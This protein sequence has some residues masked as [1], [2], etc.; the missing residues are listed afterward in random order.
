MSSRLNKNGNIVSK[1]AHHTIVHLSCILE[2]VLSAATKAI[3]MSSIFPPAHTRT[4]LRRDRAGLRHL[5]LRALLR[6]LIAVPAG[7]HRP[8]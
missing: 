4:I 6:R 1:A 3:E 8:A 5:R 2:P 7:A